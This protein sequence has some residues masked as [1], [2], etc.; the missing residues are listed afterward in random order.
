MKKNILLISLICLLLTSCNNFV[1]SEKNIEKPISESSIWVDNSVI[2]F[3]TIWEKWGEN[4]RKLIY[5]TYDS[6]VVSFGEKNNFLDWINNFDWKELIIEVNSDNFWEDFL[7]KLKW[8]RWILLTISIYSDDSNEILITKEES[9][10]FDELGFDNK[11]IILLNG[12][13][14]WTLKCEDLNSNICD[15]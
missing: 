15:N 2:S 4:L 9:S 12:S 14:I 3:E 5:K 11:E 1:K 7:N 13:K 6:L 10:I 8:S